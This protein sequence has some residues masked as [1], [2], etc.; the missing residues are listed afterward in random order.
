M[1]FPNSPVLYFAG[2]D[3]DR[4]KF[5]AHNSIF[6]YVALLLPVHQHSYST[7]RNYIKSDV[8]APFYSDSAII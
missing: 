4:I 1:R 6:H 8:C 2:F 5:L 7:V 3:K